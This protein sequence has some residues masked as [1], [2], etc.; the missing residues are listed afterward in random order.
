MLGAFDSMG[1]D[2]YCLNITEPTVSSFCFKCIWA[3]GSPWSSIYS[4][5]FSD[6]KGDRNL[7]CPPRDSHLDV[8]FLGSGLN[9]LLFQYFS[10]YI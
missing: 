9:I 7:S 4:R 6:I 3:S 2:D 8:P 1:T 5:R 10:R